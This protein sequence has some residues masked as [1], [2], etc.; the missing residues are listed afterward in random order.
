LTRSRLVLA[1]VLLLLLRGSTAS[2]Q[3]ISI[4]YNSNLFKVIGWQASA[5]PSGG[6]Q[7]IFAVYVEGANVPLLGTYAV[8][9]RTLTFRPQYPLSAGVRYRAVFHQPGA[10]AVEQ[11]FNGPPR[12]T[13][14]AARV[15]HVYPSADILPSNQLRLYIYFSAPMSRGEFARRIHLLDKDG[16]EL[17]AEFLPGEELWD[18]NGERLTLTF[19]PGRIKRGLTSNQSMGPPIAE[20]QRYT[21]VVDREWPDARGVPLV[22]AYRKVFRGGPPIRVPPDPKLWRVTAPHAG[23]TEPL[24]VDF[25][26][27]MNYPLLQRMLQVAAA[28][29]RVEGTI[30]VD[31]QE[32][33]WRFTPKTMWTA[34]AHRLIVDTGIEDLAGNKIGQLF[35]IDVFDRVTEHITT[36]TTDVP[37]MVRP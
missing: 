7:P 27:P 35:D 13:V 4:E 22:E 1:V 6:W 17:T 5:P 18:P 30:A 23:T 33:Q 12:T 24:I 34:G 15:E 16:R 20:G 29:G 2:A 8:D 28:R 31:R 10:R 11:T 25:D 32:S 3:S 36:T 14:P 9:N 26:R 21:L 19:D 37:F